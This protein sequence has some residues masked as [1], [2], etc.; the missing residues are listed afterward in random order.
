MNKAS[1]HFNCLGKLWQCYRAR[2]HNTQHQ[3]TISLHS[4]YLRLLSDR[5]IKMIQLLWVVSVANRIVTTSS[6]WNAFCMGWTQP[7]HFE[8]A[9]DKEDDF[10]RS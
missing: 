6:W 1:I 7:P 3:H 5:N 9:K 8:H 10:R 2:T 4:V